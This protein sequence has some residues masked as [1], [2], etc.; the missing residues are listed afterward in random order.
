MGKERKKERKKGR[1]KENKPKIEN[2][3]KIGPWMLL[4]DDG[5]NGFQF[6]LFS[7]IKTWVRIGS[8][9]STR[10]NKALELAIYIVYGQFF[11]YQISQLLRTYVK[12]HHFFPQGNP[13]IAL[14]ASL[15]QTMGQLLVFAILDCPL[16][17]LLS[18]EMPVLPSPNMEFPSL[19]LFKLLEQSAIS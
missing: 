18:H 19:S 3:Q 11:L 4:K 17:K 7:E 10:P 9:G 13:C 5:R 6:I 8:T 2:K 14:V 1:E 16:S 12:D 15:M